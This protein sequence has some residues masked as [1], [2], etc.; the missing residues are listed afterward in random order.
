[1][2]IFGQKRAESHKK[3]RIKFK[4]ARRD[5]ALSIGRKRESHMQQSMRVSV[6]VPFL[7]R[8]PHQRGR[9]YENPSSRSAA[10][11]E[12]RRQQ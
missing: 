12:G 6:G 1:M 10:L 2:S 5:G 9:F 4:L 3:A 11:Q 8:I 7:K